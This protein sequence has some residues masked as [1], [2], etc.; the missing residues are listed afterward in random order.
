MRRRLKTSSGTKTPAETVIASAVRESPFIEA[1]AAASA[2]RTRGFRRS[3]ATSRK[4][5]AGAAVV[6]AGNSGRASTSGESCSGSGPTAWPVSGSPRRSNPGVIVPSAGCASAAGGSEAAGIGA[7]GAEAGVETD[8]VVAPAFDTSGV[9]SG[10]T[11]CPWPC[12]RI[13]G[14]ASLT[15]SKTVLPGGG[16]MVHSGLPVLRLSNTPAPSR[17]SRMVSGAFGM[18]GSSSSSSS[19]RISVTAFGQTMKRPSRP[20]QTRERSWFGAHAACE[21]TRRRMA[22][23]R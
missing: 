1:I 2:S 23:I 8:A 21:T 9:E 6:S 3:G 12:S 19:L 10:I 5:G 4:A 7:S 15:A 14:A 11:V 22:S 20:Y 17:I 13:S 18:P 16:S